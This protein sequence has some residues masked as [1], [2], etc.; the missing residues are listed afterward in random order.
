M[1][2]RGWAMSTAALWTF[3]GGLMLAL[4]IG[5]MDYA[6][7]PYLSLALIYLGPIALVT[8][9]VGRMEGFAVACASA[10]V[11]FAADELSDMALGI[12]PFW[13]ACAR[14]G[15]FLIV[16]AVLDGLHRSHE[17]ERTLAR[18]DPLTGTANARFLVEELYRQ[19]AGARRYGHDLTLAY[20]DL[21]NFKAIN[22]TFGHSTGD[23]LLRQVGITLSSNA[24]PTDLVARIGGD[25][26]VLVLPETNAE[27]AARAMLRHRLAVLEQMA[28]NGWAVTISVGVIGLSE[29]IDSVDAFVA[30]ADSMM[31][32]AKNAGKDLVAW[33]D[34]SA[35]SEYLD[36]REDDASL[37]TFGVEDA[38][39][40]R[41][42]PR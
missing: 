35:S 17:A 3:M 9:R 5:W 42:R 28:D 29:H 24:R 33:N 37:A 30:A 40:R 26:F 41:S 2:R 16:V 20:V 39:R 34:G 38:D 8:W 21:D 11:G 4:A 10:L 23:A 31:Y 1:E 15:V 7:G 6:S 13:N 22:D 19:M 18:T 27:A 25:E 12:V 36:D 32:K 14:L